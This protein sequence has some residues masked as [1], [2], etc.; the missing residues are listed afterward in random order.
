MEWGEEESFQQTGTRP[1]GQPAQMGEG[2][3]DLAPGASRSSNPTKEPRAGANTRSG[4]RGK[5]HDLGSDNG[6]LAMPPKHRR[7]ERRRDPL[8]FVT[9]Q[10]TAPRKW[11]GRTPNGTGRLWLLWVTEDSPLEQAGQLSRGTTAG[12][13][14]ALPRGRPPGPGPEDIRTHGHELGRRADPGATGSCAGLSLCARPACSPLPQVVQHAPQ[15][16]AERK[17]IPPKQSVKT[18]CPHVIL[19]GV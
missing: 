19:E 6:S 10:R 3:P 13:G 2:G 17:L 18:I 8:G 7:P 15:N 5:C 11:E 14:I 12:E 16:P 1:T 4:L 9:S